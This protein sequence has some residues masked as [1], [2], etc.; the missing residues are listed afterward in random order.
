MANIMNFLAC[1][2]QQ[3]KKINTRVILTLTPD[4]ENEVPVFHQF[5]KDLVDV[6][7]VLPCDGRGGEGRLPAFMDSQKLGCF[8]VADSTY[9]L[10]DGS[11][12]P[13]CKD[14]A[15]YTV[16]GNLSQDSLQSIWNSPDYVRF[17]RDVSNGVFSSF[18][19]CRRCV[20][21]RL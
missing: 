12:V 6:V 16:L 7:D 21:D 18:E 10:S 20:E 1:C 17:R 13:C 5:W 2:R 8:Q 11:V 14:W 15:G 19:V 4:N 3:K 9:I